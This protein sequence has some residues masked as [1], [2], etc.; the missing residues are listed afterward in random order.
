MHPKTN[1][2]SSTSSRSERWRIKGG[3]F[4]SPL[5]TFAATTELDFQGLFSAC[6]RFSTAVVGQQA[7][8]GGRLR[9]DLF[10]LGVARYE[11]APH[12]HVGRRPDAGL[13]DG[14]VHILY[15]RWKLNWKR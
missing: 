11:N 4:N 2:P 12:R 7:R 14:H 1:V 10:K 9:R 13:S 3:T 15:L 5:Q 8:E 6:S